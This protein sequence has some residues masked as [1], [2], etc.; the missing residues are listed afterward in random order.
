MKLSTQ[1]TPL[2]LASPR[3]SELRHA[4]GPAADTPELLNAYLADPDRVWTDSL[5]EN[6]WSSLCHQGDV[7]EA[8]YAAVPL[9]M[10]VAAR[11]SPEASLRS[12][13]LVVAIE[14][15]RASGPAMP[16]ELASAYEAAVGDL[17]RLGVRALAGASELHEVAVCCG[18]IMASRGF[19]SAARHVCDPMGGDHYV[20]THCHE[21]LSE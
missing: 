16:V 20:C 4:Y 11:A 10:V 6:L 8:S 13:S 2:D 18:A 9:L 17:E 3:W 12:I 7:Y 19:A 21:R 14:A 5:I 15:A 1:S